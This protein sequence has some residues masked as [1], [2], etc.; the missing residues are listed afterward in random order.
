MV[1]GRLQ[2]ELGRV[3]VVVER[4]TALTPDGDPIDRPGPVPESGFRGSHD[5]R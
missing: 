4:V 5:Y 2:V 3:N 1:D